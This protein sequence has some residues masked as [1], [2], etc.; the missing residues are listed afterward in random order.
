MKRFIIFMSVAFLMTNTFG[1]GYTRYNLN[2]FYGIN[3]YQASSGSG[4]GSSMNIDFN[5]QQSN[6]VFQL[7]LMFNSQNKA[8]AG[9]E[10]MYKHFSLASQ[11]RTVRPFFHYNFVYRMPT[12]VI[13]APSLLKSSSV[14]MSELQGKVTTFEHAIGFGAQVQVANSLYVEGSAGVDAYMGSHY[15][16]QKPNTLGVH[17]NN[18]GIVPSVKFGL[19]FKF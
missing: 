18:F 4:Y 1:K 17:G 7:G 11:N 6:R 16:G 3:V 10:F 9:V 13:V 5:V 2:P 8:F 19:G 12:E 15:Q 14:N